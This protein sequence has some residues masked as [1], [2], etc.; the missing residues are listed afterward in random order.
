M[1]TSAISYLISVIY[2]MLVSKEMPFIPIIALVFPSHCSAPRN[3]FMDSKA[4][5]M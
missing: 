4:K 3:Q 1:S 2:F 5:V